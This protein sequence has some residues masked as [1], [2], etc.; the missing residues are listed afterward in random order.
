VR[1]IKFGVGIVRRLEGAGDGQ[2]VTVQFPGVGL[3]KL[4]V[5]FAG[6]EPA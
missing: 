1:H 5:R 3:K 4:L 2:K 6:L